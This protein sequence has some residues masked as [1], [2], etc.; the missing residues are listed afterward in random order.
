M[1]QKFLGEKALAI[2]TR[3]CE[4]VG[5]QLKPGKSAVGNRII[6]LGL[7]GAFPAEENRFKLSIS[8]TEEKRAKWSALPTSHIKAG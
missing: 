5:I 8:L 1:I 2:F 3:F 4:L 7:L 6:F